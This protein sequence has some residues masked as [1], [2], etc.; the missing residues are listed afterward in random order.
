ME[1]GSSLEDDEAFRDAAEAAG[2]PD[3]TTG[4]VYVD[5]DAAHELAEDAAALSGEEARSSEARANLEPLESVL[6]H[7]SDSACFDAFLGFE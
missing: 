6:V 7:G 3:E 4:F 2:M 1:D 5:A